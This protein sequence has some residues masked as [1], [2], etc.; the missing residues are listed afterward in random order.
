M[1]TGSRL[2]PIF[3]IKDVDAKLDTY[4]EYTIRYMRRLNGWPEDKILQDAA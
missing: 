3:R 4:L 1:E 2:T